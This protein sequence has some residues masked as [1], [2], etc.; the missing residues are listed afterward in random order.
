MISKERL[1]ETIRAVI[2]E[3]RRAKRIPDPAAEELGAV[4]ESRVEDLFDQEGTFS[5]RDVNDSASYIEQLRNESQ[6]Q[7]AEAFLR[8]MMAWQQQRS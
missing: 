5:Y 1:E 6:R 4:L 7:S 3:F 8:E 2:Q